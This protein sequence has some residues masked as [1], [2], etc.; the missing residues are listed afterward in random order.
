ML[1]FE[2]KSVH[3]AS[4]II[5]RERRKNAATLQLIAL[6]APLPLPLLPSP[7]FAPF[8]LPLLPSPF[9]C[10]LLLVFLPSRF[11]YSGDLPVPGWGSAVLTR[12]FPDANANSI[13]PSACRLGSR[14]T[15][16]AATATAWGML[17]R[18]S[19]DMGVSATSPDAEA[20]CCTASSHNFLVK[21]VSFCIMPATTPK[22]FIQYIFATI[23]VV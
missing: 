16:S 7:P 20:S 2:S 13:L 19:D 5:V 3:H 22:L 10:A 9:L 11:P 6:P 15:T 23:Y 12:R 8:P 14:S 17:S 1:C 4:K 21:H 18:G